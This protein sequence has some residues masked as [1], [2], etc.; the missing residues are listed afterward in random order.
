M[1]PSATDLDPSALA[2]PVF[3]LA[4]AGRETLRLAEDVKGMLAGAWKAVVER[5]PALA[6]EVR[7]RD[8]RVD[9]RYNAIKLYLSQVP[10]ESMTPRDARS[11]L[12]LF[13]FTS[14]LESI[15]DTI[16]KSLC[17][18]AIRWARRGRSW[19]PRTRRICRRSMSGCAAGWRK[20]SLSWRPGTGTGAT[21]HAGGRRAG[22]LVR[23]GG[24]A[25]FWAP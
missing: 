3:A 10:G 4:N 15:G 22:A 8:D 9:E 20:W 24:T 11:Q 17:G 21:L 7:K 14:E 13:N 1:V 18:A 5:D 19:R 12:S 6:Q 2:S 23:R 25:A 16:D